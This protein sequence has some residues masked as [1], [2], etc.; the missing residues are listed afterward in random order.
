MSL[1]THVDNGVELAAVD[2]VLEQIPEG[3]P[4]VHSHIPLSCQQRYRYDLEK[5]ATQT[6]AISW[7]LTNSASR[8]VPVL[9]SVVKF[10]SALHSPAT[11][12]PLR[13]Q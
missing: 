10:A 6:A 7:Q 3:G 2:A 5:N 9:Y 12:P 4:G 1:A 11:V 8:V 13:T